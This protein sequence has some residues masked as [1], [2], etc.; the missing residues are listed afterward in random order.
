[1]TQPRELHPGVTYHVTHTTV[2]RQ[3]LLRPDAVVNQVMLFCL[4]YAAKEYGVLVHSVMV[5][6]NHFHAVVTDVRG[7]LSG[8]MHRF[9]MLSA[10][11][12][13]AHWQAQ[14]PE[15]YLEQIWSASKY[16]AVVLPNANAVI[17]AITYDATNPVKDGLVSDYRD[18]PGLKSRPGDWMQPAR[19]VKRPTGLAFKDSSKK[20]RQVQVKYVVPPALRDRA[21][22]R[23]VDDVHFQ[24]RNVTQSLRDERAAADESFLGAK[25][26]MAMSPFDSPSTP[27]VKGKRTPTFAA[28][29]DAELL[30]EGLKRVRAFRQSYR[31]CVERFVAGARDVVF[32][33]GTY[34]MRV[35]FG[36][37]CHDWSPPW[38][39]AT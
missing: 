19:S 29:G 18:W 21:P 13:I 32:P 24:I 26:V 25:A 20:D 33:A 23:A 37:T 30:K 34:L 9:D 16:N 35:R 5:E 12:L 4:F 6:S 7:N 17:D 8:F 3:F 14:Y 2:G 31:E 28:G 11:C 38:C 1:M 39:H 22:Q 15:L 36:V 27:R 10:K